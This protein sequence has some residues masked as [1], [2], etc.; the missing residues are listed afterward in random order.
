LLFEEMWS[1]S[2]SFVG[3]NSLLRDCLRSRPQRPVQVAARRQNGSWHLCESV[4]VCLHVSAWHM[5]GKR[6]RRKSAGEDLVDIHAGQIAV[7]IELIR[8]GWLKSAR[9]DAAVRSEAVG[10]ESDG[11]LRMKLLYGGWECGKGD[12]SVCDKAECRDWSQASDRWCLSVG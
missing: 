5:A 1:A 2:S 7:W 3:L 4:S 9:P 10:W 8:D 12:S 6:T 11:V